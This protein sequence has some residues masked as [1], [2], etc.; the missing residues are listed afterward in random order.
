MVSQAILKLLLQTSITFKI[1][2]GTLETFNT[3]ISLIKSMK[4]IR[5]KMMFLILNKLLIYKFK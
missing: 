5:M 3:L 1:N 4:N 2:L